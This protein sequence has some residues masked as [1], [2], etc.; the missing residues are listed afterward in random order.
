MISD[1]ELDLY[2]QRTYGIT[3]ARVNELFEEQGGVCYC[4][5]RPPKTKRLNVDHDHKIVRLPI[6]IK[7]VS[8]G[9]TKFFT[10]HV[11]ALG[12][13]WV[14][15]NDASKKAC[16]EKVKKLLKAL[17][18][19]GLLCHRCNRAMQMFGDNPAVL[20]RAIEYLDRFQKSVYA[21]N[22]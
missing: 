22:Q 4:C 2:Y 9:F 16:R 17:S 15:A 1:H 12:E 21:K 10:G 5:H 14:L 18:V 3:P 8:Y 7:T 6:V 19:R 20:H 11:P 13:S